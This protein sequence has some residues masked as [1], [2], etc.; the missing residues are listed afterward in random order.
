[1]KVL[2]LEYDAKA[3]YLL[4]LQIKYGLFDF[5]HHTL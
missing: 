2:V 5:P 1:M 4:D 3:I